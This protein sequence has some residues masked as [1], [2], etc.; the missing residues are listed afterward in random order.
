MEQGRYRDLFIKLAGV[1]FGLV[2]M[3]AG[4]SMLAPDIDRGSP[5]EKFAVAAPLINKDVF[6]EDVVILTDS[7]QQEIENGQKEARLALKNLKTQRLEGLIEERLAAVDVLTD[8]MGEIEKQ[9]SIPGAIRQDILADLEQQIVENKKKLN[10]LE[11]YI[12][13][14]SGKVISSVTSYSECDKA[15]TELPSASP[16]K[17]SLEALSWI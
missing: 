9:K 16:R 15:G 11:I 8:A 17:K 13:E 12:A 3:L 2:V 10:G 6:N 14:L 1:A 4:A 5:S 7:G